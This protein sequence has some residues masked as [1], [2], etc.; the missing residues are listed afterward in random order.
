MEIVRKELNPNDI[1]PDNLRYNPETDKVEAT[2]DGANV[3]SSSGKRPATSD[4]ISP[5]A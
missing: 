1:Y 5:R 3:V 4:K 2:N